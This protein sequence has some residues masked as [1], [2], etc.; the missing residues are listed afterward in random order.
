M[1]LSM[2][3]EGYGLDKPMGEGNVDSDVDIPQM[4]QS[5][6]TNKKGKSKVIAT[7]VTVVGK[8]PTKET[9]EIDKVADEI[10]RKLDKMSAIDLQRYY[11][12]H[13]NNKEWLKIL[14]RF[15]EGLQREI[16]DERGEGTKEDIDEL[17]NYFLSGNQPINVNIKDILKTNFDSLER[18]PQEVLDVINKKWGINAKTVKVYDQTPNRYF[19]YAKMSPST[20]KPSVMFDGYIRWGVGRFIAAL[21]RG[22]KTMK[23]WDLRE[24]Q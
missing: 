23:V 16:I 14:F 18:T 9:Y 8:V 4:I 10:D 3:A 20:A 24:K 2:I 13:E 11:K 19:E 22:D 12:K 21:V 17:K 7:K 1:K 5:I 15:P 6:S